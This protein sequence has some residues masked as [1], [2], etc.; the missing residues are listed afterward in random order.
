MSQR[1]H[2]GPE[3]FYFDHAHQLGAEDGLQYHGRLVHVDEL[4]RLYVE[5]RGSGPPVVF[6]PG[7]GGD[8][9]LFVYL[10]DALS[11]AFTTI[12]YDRRGNSRSRRGWVKVSLEEQADDIAR[13]LDV[14]GYERASIMSSSNGGSVALT[15]MLRHTDRLDRGVLHEP[16]WTTAF[17]TDPSA[18]ATASVAGTHAI[19]LRREKDCGELEA[20]LRYLGGDALVEWFTAETRKRMGENAET[21][22]IEREVFSRWL[23]SDAEWARMARLPLTLLVGGDTL[24]FFAESVRLF[25]KKLGLRALTVPGGHGGFVDFADECAEV[26]RPYLGPAARDRREE[27]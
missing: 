7:Y 19:K 21:G 24:P 5:R 23:P 26:V 15:F 3:P 17:L 4:Q 14:L 27:A 12:T 10:A 11:D 13:L 1:H 20:R 22:A 8:A 2:R 9:A 18:M 25:E 16:F 6:V